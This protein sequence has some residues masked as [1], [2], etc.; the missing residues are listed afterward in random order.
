MKFEAPGSFHHSLMVASLCETAAEDID[1][2]PLLCR[3]GA[4][5]HDVGKIAAPEYFIENKNFK[6]NTSSLE[7]GTFSFVRG[8]IA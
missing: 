2:N 3:V 6:F 5:Y 1:A 8:L 4:Y 7:I